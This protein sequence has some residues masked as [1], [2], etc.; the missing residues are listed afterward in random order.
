MDKAKIFILNFLAILIVSMFLFWVFGKGG[1]QRYALVNSFERCVKGGYPVSQSSPRQCR[2]PNGESFTESLA[3]TQQCVKDG[4]C[5]AGKFCS[6]GQCR[7]F[8]A[9]ASCQA[10]ADC[11]LINKDLNFGCCWAGVCQ[12][13]DYSKDNWVAVNRRWFE[14]SRTKACSSQ[15]CGLEPKCPVNLVN[16]SFEARCVGGQCIKLPVS[17]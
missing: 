11:K 1:Q 14:D 15:A 13:I 2:L 17:R 10:T 16:D 7:D 3:V 4:D 8:F 5:G 9:N 12:P 6:Q